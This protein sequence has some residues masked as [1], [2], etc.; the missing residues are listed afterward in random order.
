MVNL[1]RLMNKLIALILSNATLAALIVA[2]GPAPVVATPVTWS[3][4]ETAITSCSNPGSC[5]LPPQPFVFITLALPGP[6]SNGTATWLG[7]VNQPVYT[8]DSFALT[9]GASFMRPLTPSFMGGASNPSGSAFANGG[10]ICDFN[11]SWSE[12]AGQLTAV[13]INIDLVSDNIGGMA[14]RGAFRPNRRPDSLGWHTRRLWVHVI[15]NRWILAERPVG[16][17]ARLCGAVGVRSV[18]NLARP[19]PADRAGS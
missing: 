5:V 9:T 6:T 4:Y 11:I 2:I 12:T 7:T 1:G 16:A 14:G 15:P 8:G 19:A 18:R 10:D 17:G 3:F 13:D